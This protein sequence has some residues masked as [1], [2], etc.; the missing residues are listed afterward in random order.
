MLE[1]ELFVKPKEQPPT[2]S[3]ITLTMQPA[4]INM[5]LFPYLV[6][7][8]IMMAPKAYP[9]RQVYPFLEKVKLVFAACVV[10][11]FKLTTNNNLYLACFSRITIFERKLYFCKTSGES[12]Y[13]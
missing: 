13:L 4:A 6:Y 8:C 7:P 9:H 2:R 11:D 5:H 10:E 3:I 1:E 12:F